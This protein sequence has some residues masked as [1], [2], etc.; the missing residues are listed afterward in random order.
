[1]EQADFGSVPSFMLCER[2]AKLL[3]SCCRVSSA[4]Y[5]VK[6]GIGSDRMGFFGFLYAGEQAAVVA[7]NGGQAGGDIYG[8]AISYFPIQPWNMT[9]SAAQT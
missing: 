6:S 8:G 4:S 2:R 3:R 9:F 1:M 7:D 5:F